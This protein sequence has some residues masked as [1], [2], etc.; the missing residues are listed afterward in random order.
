[1]AIRN[2]K[3]VQ[4]FITSVMEANAVPGTPAPKS[5]HKAF[6][7]TMSYTDFVNGNVPGVLDPVTK[8]PLPILVKGSPDTSN[9]ILALRGSGPLFDPQRGAFGRMPANGQTPFTEEQITEL[10]AWIENGC[11]E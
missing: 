11:P 10:A 4:E 5:P 9:L 6:W 1:M 8:A 7:A 2:Y 3:E